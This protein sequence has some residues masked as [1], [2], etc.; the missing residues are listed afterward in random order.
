[1]FMHQDWWDLIRSWFEFIRPFHNV[2]QMLESSS[3]R[4]IYFDRVA[5]PVCKNTFPKTSLNNLQPLKQMQ[6]LKQSMFFMHWAAVVD[7]VF[8]M[9]YLQGLSHW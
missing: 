8:R 4:F 3:F 7:G 1:M 2:N 6:P 5:N 9:A